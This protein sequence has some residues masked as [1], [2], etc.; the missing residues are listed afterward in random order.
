MQREVVKTVWF[1][2][3]AVGGDDLDRLEPDSELD[4]VGDDLERPARDALLLRLPTGLPNT[5]GRPPL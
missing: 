5:S 4:L 3:V 2:V 1:L